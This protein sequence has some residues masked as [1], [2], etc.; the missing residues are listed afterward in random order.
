[1]AYKVPKLLTTFFLYINKTDFHQIFIEALCT[2]ISGIIASKIRHVV[3]YDLTEN[4]S[5]KQ[6][7]RR[8][9][10]VYCERKDMT[11]LVLRKDFLRR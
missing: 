7:L 6:L 5:F 10:A 11:V 9:R 4:S 1:M 2:T 3:T 8:K